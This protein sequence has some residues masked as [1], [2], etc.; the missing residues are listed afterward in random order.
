LVALLELFAILNPSLGKNEF[1]NL[2]F[3][4]TEDKDNKRN[5]TPLIS[6]SLPLILR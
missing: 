1:S 5:F 2:F 3:I 6:F 4:K